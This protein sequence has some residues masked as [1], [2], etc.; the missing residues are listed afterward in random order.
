MRLPGP[1]SGGGAVP[2]HTVV[3]FHAHPDDE[4]LLTGGTIARLAAEGHRVL[5][6]TATDGEAG[7]TDREAAREL[8]PVRHRELGRAADLLGCREVV[9]LGYPDSGM[10]EA[11][12]R[13][14]AFSRVPVE[15]VAAR[16]A[17][18]LVDAR[19]DV[20]C[21]YD[22][23]GGYGHPDHRQVH[24]VARR[25][26]E[27]AGVAVLLEATI[28][29]RFLRAALVAARPFLP[30][31]PQ[32]RSQ[33]LRA[34]FAAPGEITHTVSVGRYAAAKR[35]A[36]HAHASQA[37]GGDQERLLAWLLRLPPPAFRAVLG[38]EW[39][40]QVGRRPSRVRS[41]AL[42]DGVPPL[43]GPAVPGGDHPPIGG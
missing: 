41:R 42:L 13:P 36:M 5:I 28:D 37:V 12:P 4:V 21:G 14:G 3:F 1:R 39:F 22:A 24:R 10:D 20:L 32:Y 38:H 35:L 34:A 43:Q 16:L 31:D 33:R 9:R 26:A 30:H 6:V 2:R 29:R 7:L 18:L 40:V 19:A 27:I 11:A 17:Q 25:A 23:A 15:P 8:G